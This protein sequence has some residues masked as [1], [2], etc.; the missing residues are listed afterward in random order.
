MPIGSGISGQFGYSAATP[1]WDSNTT[2]TKFLEVD[3]ARLT[4]KPN[5][6]RS[7]GIRSGQ[8]LTR[9]DDS[10]IVT[11]EVDGE[12]T[13]DLMTSEMAT[14]FRH[15]LG[16]ISTTGPVST[17]YTHVITPGNKGG[18]GIA[19]QLGIPDTAGVVQPFT[20]TGLKVVGFE[21]SWS[22]GAV[23]SGTFTLMGK[24]VTTGTALA[25]ASY[26]SGK[27][28]FFWTHVNVTVAGSAFK[29]TEG[30]ISYT[31][32]HAR[33]FYTGTTPTLTDEPLQNGTGEATFD[34]TGHFEGLT[35]YDRVIA[36][37]EAAVSVA[38]T[39][40]TDSITFA[41]NAEFDEGQP[42]LAG[43]DIVDQPYSGLFSA[44]GADS[45]GF[46]VTVVSSEATA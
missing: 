28:S 21:V 9:S 34:F 7:E 46:T 10:A 24:D 38:F 13:S 20:G 1:N 5:R 37:T 22:E 12:F 4:K 32:P 3:N 6:A 39:R 15:A 19:G 43:M 25:T 8:I 41:G 29:T 36:G 35:A 44:T 45:T 18:L 23:V 26:T 42:E 17:K 31:Q 30:T 14:L 16:S 2:P 27:N 11:Y 33:R 40:G